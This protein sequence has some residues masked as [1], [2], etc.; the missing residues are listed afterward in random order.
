MSRRPI[1]EGRA[2][3]LRASPRPMNACVGKYRHPRI[4]GLYAP[5]GSVN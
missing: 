4:R 2:A 5:F 1:P 3:L